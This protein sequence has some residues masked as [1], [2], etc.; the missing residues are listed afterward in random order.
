MASEHELARPAPAESSLDLPGGRLH[1]WTYEPAPADA[2]SNKSTVDIPAIVMVHGFRGTHHGLAAIAAALPH[3]RVIAP[4]LPGFGRS[5]ALPTGTNTVAGY[6]ETIA[7]LI[8][9][10]PSLTAANDDGSTRPIILLGH[11]FGSV[12]AAHLAA[13]H[14]NLVSRLILVN[15]IAANPVT[16]PAG[17]VANGYYRLGR[18]LPERAGRWLLANPL[19]VL[20]VSAVMARTRNRRL[21]RAIHREHLTYFSRFQHVAVLQEA[22]R[23]SISGTVT[24]YATRLT[25]PTLLVAGEKDSIAPLP[26]QRKLAEILPDGRL[27]SIPKVGHLTHYETPAEVAAHITDFLAEPMPTREHSAGDH[28]PVRPEA[29]G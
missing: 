18:A 16:G 5:P 23:A 11:S 7:T 21:R 4:D 24:P 27:R 10:E 9:S 8:E 28:A 20:G 12:I 13:T 3:H 17:A 2:A 25:M 26:T 19:M 1:Y 15:P 6:A 22:F 14:P 29:T